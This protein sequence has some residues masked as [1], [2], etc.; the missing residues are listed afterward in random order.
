MGFGHHG[1]QVR[2]DVRTGY[3]RGQAAAQQY[4]QQYAQP[5]GSQ[6]FDGAAP[7]GQQPGATR[8]QPAALTTGST[9]TPRRGTV[10]EGPAGHDD[11]LAPRRAFGDRGR[12]RPATRPG[13]ADLS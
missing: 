13:R 2:A 4:T 3:D 5:G 1:D 9:P 10:H 11:Q 6:P 7:Y 12:P 8:A